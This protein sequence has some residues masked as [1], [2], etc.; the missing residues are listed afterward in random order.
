MIMKLINTLTIITWVAILLVACGG[1]GG[2]PLNGTTWEL[3]SM[4][5]YSPIPGSRITLQF[6]DGQVSGNGGCNS[7]GGEYQVN[8]DK[9]EIG[10]LMST[11][12]ACVDPAMMEQETIFM[13]VLGNAQSFD[14]VDGQLQISGSDGETLTFVPAE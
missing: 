8:G 9:I 7:Y 2:D 14:I 11:L 13:G 3:Y 4:G 1:T 6:E 5:Q 12:M 10:M